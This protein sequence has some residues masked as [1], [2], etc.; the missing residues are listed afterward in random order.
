MP[1]RNFSPEIHEIMKREMAEMGSF[2]IKKQCMELGMMPDYITSR[3]IPKLSKALSE[4][5]E[6]FG[7]EK[8]N[9]VVRDMR[10][11]INTEKARADE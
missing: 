11:L 7:S 3:D 5:M 1:S 2:F 10:R 6:D 4:A 8:S 9:R